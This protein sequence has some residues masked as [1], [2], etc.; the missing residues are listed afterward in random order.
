MS[1]SLEAAF[2]LK[3]IGLFIDLVPYSKFSNRTCLYYYFWV[4]RALNDKSFLVKNNACCYVCGMIALSNSRV[5][6]N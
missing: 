3:I 1:M 5:N 6:V 2:C 4:C